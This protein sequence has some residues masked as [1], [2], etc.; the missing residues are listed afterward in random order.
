MTDEYL[1]DDAGNVHFCDVG[2]CGI[3]ASHE[4]GVFRYCEKHRD[5]PQG[6]L[7]TRAWRGRGPQIWLELATA[8]RK[9]PIVSFNG[10]R[11]RWTEF[12]WSRPK[13]GISIAL[14]DPRNAVLQ[15]MAD[16]PERLTISTEEWT[17]AILAVLEGDA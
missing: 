16:D 10:R 13:D 14:D 4:V 8:A 12:R 6:S 9:S 2:P 17:Q 5:T 7:W 15:A 11:L 1:R 3:G